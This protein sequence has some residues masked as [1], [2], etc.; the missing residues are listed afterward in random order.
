[1]ET[2][3]HQLTTCIHLGHA[4]ARLVSLLPPTTRVCL[5]ASILDGLVLAL[6]AFHHS[7]NYRAAVLHGEVVP[8]DENGDA[9]PVEE[10]GKWEA[11]KQVVEKVL[12][13]RWE[14]CRQPTDAE[15]KSTGF[16]K[17]KVLSARL[18]IYRR[19]AQRKETGVLKCLFANSAKIRAGPPKDDKKDLNDEVNTAKTWTGVIPGV[20]CPFRRF[21][22]LI[23]LGTGSYPILRHANPC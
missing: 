4:K 20:F 23:D 6:V 9:T 18:V 17:V 1:M 12:D 13:G 15:M 2:G 11:A 21:Y 3:H 22:T 7:M 5:T 8:F 16:I 10:E 14:A 19:V